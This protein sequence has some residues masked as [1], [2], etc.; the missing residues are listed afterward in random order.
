MLGSLFQY[1]SFAPVIIAG[2]EKFGE[3]CSR[4]QA[5]AKNK[6]GGFARPSSRSS[7]QFCRSKTYH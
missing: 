4:N 5:A 2:I 3:F 7:N 1:Y 6:K